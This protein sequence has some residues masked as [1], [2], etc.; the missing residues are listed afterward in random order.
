MKAF[1]IAIFVLSTIMLFS[2]SVFKDAFWYLFG[3]SVVCWAVLE[4]IQTSDVSFSGSVK[5][6]YAFLRLAV[7]TNAVFGSLLIFTKAIG[8]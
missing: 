6:K 2:A 4:Y 5:D 1:S 3:L 8:V 7:I